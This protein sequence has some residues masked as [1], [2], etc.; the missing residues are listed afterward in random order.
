MMHS[1]LKFFLTLAL[2]VI[3]C[4]AFT[5]A[6]AATKAP[7]GDLTIHSKD[8]FKEF[9]QGPVKFSHEKHKASKCEDCHHDYKDGK[10]VWK[11]GMEVKKCGACHKL[12]AEGKV[13][14]LEKA[15]HDNCQNCHKKLKG[16]NKPTGPVT[17]AKC[18]EKKAK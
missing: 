8:V 14:K 5:L 13:V 17:C 11:E 10:N 6:F 7:E 9:K 16:E 15:Y 3:I 2:T 12:E 1:R 18:H 4:A